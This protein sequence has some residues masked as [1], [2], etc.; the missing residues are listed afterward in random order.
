MNVVVTGAGS[1]IGRAVCH[2][3]AR[4]P[5]DERPPGIVVV[6]LDEERV[7]MVSEQLTALDASPLGLVG[8]LAEP[9]FAQ[10][11]IDASLARFGMLDAIVS[12]AGILGN[13]A[14]AE[15]SVR[16]WDRT[17]AINTR[18]TWLLARAAYPA[19]RLRGGTI[20]ATA[21]ISATQPTPP[22]GAYS[23]SKAALVMLV[24]QLA[25]EWGPDGIR[26]N[27]VSPGTVHTGMSDN[28]YSQPENKA[29][30]SEAVP[31]RRV[32]DPQDVAAVICFLLSDAAS[33][34]TGENIAVDGGLHTVLMPAVRGLGGMS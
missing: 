18:A 8:D 11:V 31:L 15:L 16:E 7:R 23:A 10:E 14:L 17:F 28:F 13:A 19:L 6:D 5:V 30:R 22:H 29:R 9:S 27:S 20:V 33:Y 21:S 2:L 25:N 12:N 1:G 34:V 3:L 4:S 24:Q 26:V 32:A